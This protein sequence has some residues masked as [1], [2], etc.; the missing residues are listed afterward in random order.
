MPR[1]AAFRVQLREGPT[2]WLL[3]VSAAAYLMI[4]LL[5]VNASVA[6]LCGRVNSVGLLLK[7]GLPGSGF[8]PGAVAADWILMVVAMMTPLVGAH[9]AYIGRSVHPSQ[10]GPAITAF[11]LGYLACWLVSGVVLVPAALLLAS[12][13]SGAD[14]WLATAGA[15]VWSL[16]PL[17][18]AARNRCHQLGRVAAF[19]VDAQADSCWL[20][21]KTGVFC[22]L[23]CWPFMLIPLFVQSGHFVTMIGI[24]LYLFADRVAPG[25]PPRWRL[26]PALET[27]FGVSLLRMVQPRASNP[28]RLEK[29]TVPVRALR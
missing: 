29:R 9:V 21:L 20:G 24:G 5:P 19:G 25:A 7:P 12:L 10:K 23:V 15:I 28:V 6:A 1:L 11:V 17:A 16:S 13:G 2:P 22:I 27:L 8:D 4:A 14:L 26:P 18:Q 3:A